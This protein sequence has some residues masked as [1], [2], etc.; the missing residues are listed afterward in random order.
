[1]R[2]GNGRE[3]G[4]V[5]DRRGGGFGGGRGGGRMVVGGGLGTVVLVLLALFF[6]VD[7]GVILNGGGP[8]APAPQ[9]NQGPAQAPPQD[10]A[11]A[12]FASRVLAETESGTIESGQFLVERMQR[13]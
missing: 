2:L 4:N 12:R 6:G 1:M 7:P 3:S 8:V 11:A 9:V 10:D 13:A 5:E